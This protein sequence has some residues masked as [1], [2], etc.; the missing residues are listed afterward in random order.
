MKYAIL[1]LLL[2]GCSGSYERKP[3]PPITPVPGATCDDMCAHLTQLGCAEAMPTPKGATCNEVC[4][5]TLEAGYDLHTE[6]VVGITIC[7]DVD[8]ASQGNC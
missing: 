8:R 4:A 1:G 7:E 3:L 2:F 5:S 6:C